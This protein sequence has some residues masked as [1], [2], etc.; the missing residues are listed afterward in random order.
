MSIIR[1]VIR[2]LLSKPITIE[3]PRKLTPIEKDFRGRH[4]ADLK[5]CTGCSLCAIECPSNCISMEKL[6][7]NIKLRHN[8]RG[9]YPNINYMSCVFCYRCVKVC[10]VNAYITTNEYRLSSVKEV[11]SK[12]LTI[13]T[14][15]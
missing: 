8:P 10:P 1:D 11:Y 2:N 5:K 9:L 7:E 4:Y 12:E 3:Y 13:Q 15:G 14:L 6:P